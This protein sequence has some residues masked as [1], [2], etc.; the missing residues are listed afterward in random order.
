MSAAISLLEAISPTARQLLLMPR[1]GLSKSEHHKVH[2]ERQDGQPLCGG[3]FQ[4][5]RPPS[6]QGDIGPVN[7]AACLG[8][9]ERRAK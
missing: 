5:R 3:G 9:I 4:A 1:R 7:C 2:A 8:I 6:W